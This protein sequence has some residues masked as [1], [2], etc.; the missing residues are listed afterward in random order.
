MTL[1][2]IVTNIGLVTGTFTYTPTD[3]AK[4]WI[5]AEAVPDDDDEDEDEL[6]ELTKDEALIYASL[7]APEFI[8]IDGEE[9][10]SIQGSQRHA[11]AVKFTNLAIAKAER[12]ANGDLISVENLGELADTIANMPH[13]DKHPGKATPHVI[14]VFAGGRVV[15]V[16]S[17]DPA[18]AGFYTLAD[19]LWWSGR[20]PKVVSELVAG[21]RKP[22]IEAVSER[23]GCSVC[24][25]WFDYPSQ[26]CA[27][28][29]AFK[30]SVRAADNVSRMHKNMKAMGAAA[31]PNPAGTNTGFHAGKFYMVAEE[32]PAYDEDSGNVEAEVQ[33]EHPQAT[34]QEDAQM[35]LEEAIARIAE[36]EAQVADA[37][38]KLEAKSGEFDAE[39]AKVEAARVE[40]PLIIARAATLAST[41][42]SAEEI[43]ALPIATWDE[44]TFGL[45]V[46]SR[47]IKTKTE[48]STGTKFVADAK[49]DPAPPAPT[50]PYALFETVAVAA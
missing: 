38:A 20:H 1:D 16:R 49:D 11:R 37:N 27:H 40:K 12:N 5:Y 24:G 19:G 29:Q 31:V 42:L 35:I 15:E 36:L 50:N 10:A 22:S 32:L 7:P 28:L 25:A 43:V 45:I 21:T 8:D 34:T 39:T 6:E 44:A 47:N 17:P 18:E 14:G 23:T 3:S 48:T 13:T 26:Y 41:G 2:S 9:P 33:P 46:A 30:S 4:A